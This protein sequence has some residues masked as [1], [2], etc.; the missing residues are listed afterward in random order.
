MLAMWLEELAQTALLE[1]TSQM[2][3][4]FVSS[5]VCVFRRTMASEYFEKQ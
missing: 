2:A 4:G 5:L 1:R 3:E